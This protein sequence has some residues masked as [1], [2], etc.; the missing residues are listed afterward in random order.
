MVGSKTTTTRATMVAVTCR[1]QLPLPPCSEERGPARSLRTILRK[2]SLSS[3]SPEGMAPPAT[4]E[5]TSI[6]PILTISQIQAMPSILQDPTTRL[7]GGEGSSL[8]STLKARP[9]RLWNM[10]VSIARARC[11]R[12]ETVRIRRKLRREATITMSIRRLRMDTGIL[13]RHRRRHLLRRILHQDGITTC[14][15]SL[16]PLLLSI[17]TKTTATVTRTIGLQWPCQLLIKMRRRIRM[18]NSQGW[19]KRPFCERNFLGNTI[20]R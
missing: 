10:G 5:A 11:R 16:T 2:T 12:T 8:L 15:M 3:G 18:C 9:P 1:S 19:K 7:V 20:Q 6:H 4:P 13:I 14:P 17:P